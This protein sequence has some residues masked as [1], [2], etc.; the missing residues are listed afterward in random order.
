MF[1]G[2]IQTI[3]ELREVKASG[4]S[5]RMVIGCDLPLDQVA[6]GASIACSGVCLSVIEKGNDWFTV[7]ISPETLARTNI[8]AWEPGT[9]IN[10]E[11]SL[12]LGDELGGHF[13]FGHVDGLTTLANIETIDDA[14]KLTITVPPDCAQYVASKGS[15][16][17]DGVSLTVNDVDGGLFTV[18]I[19]P[20]T[21]KVTTLSD[22]KAGDKMHF[23]ADMLAR[24]VAN[25]LRRAA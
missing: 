1:T 5:R 24:Y 9:R 22:L 7:D 23:E 25:M 12:K 17:L 2:L 13:V 20:H 8:G 6:I 21:W 19:I 18:M 14:H 10:L 15:V 4:E 16:A 11:P 3:G